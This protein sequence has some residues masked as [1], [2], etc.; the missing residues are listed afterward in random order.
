MLDSDSE[1]II[2]KVFDAKTSEEKRPHTC[3]VCAVYKREIAKG[4]KE[5][6]KFYKDHIAEIARKNNGVTVVLYGKAKRKM[7][8]GATEATNSGQ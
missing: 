1:K 2:L 4:N 5:A 7:L 3:S 6:L 8:A